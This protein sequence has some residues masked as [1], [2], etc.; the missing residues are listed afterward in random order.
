[1]MLY[2]PWKAPMG[3]GH[4]PW[5][6]THAVIATQNTLNSPISVPPKSKKQKLRILIPAP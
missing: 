4:C 5:P 3:L 2:V 1:M 6:C